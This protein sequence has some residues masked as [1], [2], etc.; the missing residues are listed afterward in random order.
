[1]SATGESAGTA[2]GFEQR[3]DLGWRWTWG[4]LA[5]TPSLGLG[6]H[7]DVGGGLAPAA[8]P[9]IGLGLAVGMML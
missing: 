5:I 3:L 4:R 1:M 9:V 6:V 2:W 8:H 7:E